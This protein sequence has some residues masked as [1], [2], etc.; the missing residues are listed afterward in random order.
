MRP[1]PQHLSAAQPTV[2]QQAVAQPCAST[3]SPADR[4]QQTLAA[5]FAP[6]TSAV[7]TP[8]GDR[9]EDIPMYGILIPSPSYEERPPRG[10]G[11]SVAAGA[12]C[13]EKDAGALGGA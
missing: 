1:A 5:S 3:A 9:E 10:C 6:S 7:H 12:G 11:A 13:G 2:R 4:G 8:C